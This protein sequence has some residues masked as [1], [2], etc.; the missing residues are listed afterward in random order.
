MA[1]HMETTYVDRQT[2]LKTSP[3]RNFE[4]FP[5]WY[6]SVHTKNSIVLAGTWYD[7]RNAGGTWPR[8]TRVRATLPPV[9]YNW[10]HTGPSQIS[11]CI[12]IATEVGQ[13]LRNPIVFFFQK[14]HLDDLDQLVK[15]FRLQFM[16]KSL[17]TWYIFDVH[18]DITV[19]FF[20]NI[21]I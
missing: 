13:G 8:R 1:G 16:V 15:N 10:W 14:F 17:C 20:F 18:S 12:T 19:G 5:D 9:T 7:T 3:S 6:I 4:N 2:R 21:S 11:S